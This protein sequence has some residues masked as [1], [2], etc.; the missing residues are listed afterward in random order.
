MPVPIRSSQRAVEKEAKQKDISLENVY[1]LFYFEFD[2]SYM[3]FGSGEKSWPETMLNSHKVSLQRKDPINF[4]KIGLGRF[5]SMGSNDLIL[6]GS[7][8][9]LIFDP[10]GLRKK[11]HRK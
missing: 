1:F 6:V 3:V 8:R 9:E 2:N 10:G 4:P 11:Y 5:Q 7:K